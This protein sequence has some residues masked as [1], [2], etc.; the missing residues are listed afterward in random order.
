MSKPAIG[1]IARLDANP[2][3]YNIWQDSWKDW[4][5]YLNCEEIGEYKTLP[6]AM[7]AAY[8]DAKTRALKEPS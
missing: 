5:V 8:F 3:R 7:N 6:E 4:Q 2:R 1:T